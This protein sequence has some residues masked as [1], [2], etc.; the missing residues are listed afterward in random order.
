MRTRLL[1]IHHELIQR[2]KNVNCQRWICGSCHILDPEE[3]GIIG[4]QNQQK[5]KSLAE[6]NMSLEGF[7]A[8]IESITKDYKHE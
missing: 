5:L 4:Y 7:F 6:G 8:C 3:C 1:D 2:C